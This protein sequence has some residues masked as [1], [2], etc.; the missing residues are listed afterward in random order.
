MANHD[1]SLSDLPDELIQNIFHYL[2]SPS[3]APLRL[4]SKRFDAL[5]EE[6]LLWRD[7]CWTEF[8][9]WDPRHSIQ[10]KFTEPAALVN[11][12]QLY[13][14]RF[15]V[16]RSTTTELNSLLTSQ[17]GRIEK[18]QTI[19]D[20][21]Y[22]AKD[23]LLRHTRCDCNSEDVLA[24]RYYADA[25]LGCI[26]R[27]LAI[28]EWCKIK[29]GQ[30]VPLERAL[31]AFDMFVVQNREHDLDEIS[32]RLDELAQHFRDTYSDF[33]TLSPRNQA[34]QLL[35]FARTKRLT[36]LDEG[37][38]YSDIKNRFL[39][40]AL[41]S[42]DHSSLPLLS[43][44]IYCSLARRLGL[45]A[46]PCAF[47][48][49]VHAI[50][51]APAETTL[52]GRSRGSS[53]GEERQRMFLDPWRSDT[54]IPLTDLEAQLRHIGVNPSEFS[55]YL[56]ASQ[57]N[58]MVLRNAHNIINAIQEAREDDPSSIVGD[59]FPNLDSAFYGALWASLLLG[60]LQRRHHVGTLVRRQY[61]PYVVRHFETHFPMDASLIEDYILPLFVN[62]PEFTQLLE[63]VRVIRAGD[64]VPKR[65]LSRAGVADPSQLPKQK[66]GSVFRHR[67]YAYDA[68]IIGWDAECQAG[69]HWMQQMGIDRL[70]RGRHQSFYHA[71][72]DDQTVRYVAE[73][74]LQII[75]PEQPPADLLISAGK[76][77]K[78]W[79]AERCVF[80]SNIKDEY[81][82]D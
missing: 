48:F 46:R 9:Y 81:P 13:I 31:G 71:L 38:N 57:P 22:D 69:E 26:Q 11:W 61:L 3:L 55:S 14:Y 66:V 18:I 59:H 19:A 64:S 54:E 27:K 34:L 25:V 49:H 4:V 30:D 74:N 43:V 75:H 60:P 67:R 76:Y 8:H 6:P 77:F 65:V 36:G 24:R 47:P 17:T 32:E 68:V 28:D 5:A 37:H 51:Q 23:T 62:A 58:E 35:D 1:I 72:V 16:D 42:E 56:G 63:T 82:D 45:D 50:V 15:R 2:A 80:V 41:F 33:D 78:R 79:D 29:D 12:K 53:E 73:E 20:H 40:I 39:G 10:R 21:G 52:D 44:T 70:S 7:R